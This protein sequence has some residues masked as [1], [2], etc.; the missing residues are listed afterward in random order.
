MRSN[1]ANRPS[2]G[3][4]V[5]VVGALTACQLLPGGS[6]E[7][8]ASASAGG[9][10]VAEGRRLADQGQL[11]AALAKLQEAPNDPESL[12]LQGIV[13]ARK[14]ERA[15]APQALEE[16]GPTPEFKV[17]ERNALAFFETLI[18]AM[19]DRA[20]AH[21][22]AAELLAPHAIAHA[23]KK[24]GQAASGVP[25]EPDF[26]A[27]RVMATYRK[28]AELGEGPEAVE[29]MIEFCKQLEDL[30]C[31]GD[32]FLHLIERAP[33]S[34]D[35]RIRYGDYLMERKQI[36][37]AARQYDIALVWAPDDEVTRGKLASIYIE[38][39]TRHLRARE[40]ARAEEA[41]RRAGEYIKDQRSEQARLLAER[42]EELASGSG[43]R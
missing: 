39:G 25:G 24:K 18:E 19:P 2:L 17:E 26:S 22:A 41:L 3:M 29:G 16:G 15:P 4:C 6:G 12:Y 1:R 30:A 20:D 27:D 33:E 34:A 5:V 28:A 8:T 14:A 11:D 40:W 31:V 13:W 21:L 43:R 36:E 32:G 23:G 9:G 42:R 37:E 7:Q 10:P 38:Q 35:P